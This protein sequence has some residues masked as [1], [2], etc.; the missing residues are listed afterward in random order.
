MSR[1]PLVVVVLDGGVGNQLFQYAAGLSIARELGA[2]LAVRGLG[3]NGIR[4]DEFLGGGVQLATPEMIQQLALAAPLPLVSRALQHAR[5]RWSTSRGQIQYVRQGHQE[6]YAPKPPG[7]VTEAT[8]TVLLDGYFQHPSWFSS[9]LSDI[10]HELK[11]RLDEG[12][13]A[14]SG[15]GAT[16]ISFRRGDYVRLDWALPMSYYDAALRSLEPLDGPV[17]VIGDDSVLI[18][19]VGDWL[20]RFGMEVSPLPDLGVPPLW[21]DL[22]LLSTA[23]RVVMSNSTY[24]WWGVTAGD[25]SSTGR[26]RTIVAPA[27]WLPMKGSE[28]L[29]RPTWRVVG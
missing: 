11:R 13:V 26:E 8:T 4:L 19:L 6:A 17:W 28:A 23:Q 7:I 5:R 24:C 1:A 15:R 22:I 10:A 29:I 16:V 3:S 20:R 18:G 25:A 14:E 27:Y 21:R 2:T 12:S 9:S